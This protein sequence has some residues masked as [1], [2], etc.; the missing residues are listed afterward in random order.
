M[1]IRLFDCPSLKES[2]VNS[3]RILGYDFITACN[4][5]QRIINDFKQSKRKIETFTIKG[6]EI[7][8]RQTEVLDITLKK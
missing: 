7:N 8:A 4:I 3:I 2:L 1:Q 5:A 6:K